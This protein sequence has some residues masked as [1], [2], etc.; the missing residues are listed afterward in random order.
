[1][2]E[3][4]VGSLCAKVH[5]K[6]F[7]TI[8]EQMPSSLKRSLNETLVSED[9]QVSFFS[10]LKESPPAA[11]ISSLKTYLE[12]YKKLE[13]ITLEHFDSSSFNSSLT[14][15][16]FGLAKY[17]NAADLKRFNK[18][19]RLSWLICFLLE[20][21]KQLLDNII[22]MHDQFMIELS[23]R[24]RN[25]Y[26]KKHRQSRRRYKRAV[27]ILLKTSD[28]LLDWQADFPLHREDVFELAREDKLRE[29]VA[30]LYEFKYLSERGYADLLISHYPSLRKYFS[31]FISLPFEAE[32]G[33]EELIK[34]IEIIRRGGF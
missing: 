21:R 34:A 1:M 24:T 25:R 9:N 14:D 13:E 32:A 7:E 23:R 20:A 3:R 4:Q 10:L 31:D 22:K 5:S 6:I 19:K 30:D 17:Y 2:L 29:S 12:R 18:Q 27:D 28:I 33:S 26:E 16:L 11:K 8:Y 15:Y